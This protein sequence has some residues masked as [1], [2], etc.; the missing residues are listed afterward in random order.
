[1][2]CLDW[3]RLRGSLA[4]RR[5]AQGKNKGRARPGASGTNA[6]RFL[7]LILSLTHRSSSVAT[8]LSRGH[9]VL[10]TA[11]KDTMTD[12]GD[13]RRGDPGRT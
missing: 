10:L 8:G 6:A 2:G 12:D 5:D 1:M 13:M 4:E 9:D 7:Y 11:R 3:G